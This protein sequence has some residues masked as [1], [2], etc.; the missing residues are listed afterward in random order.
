M[1]RPLKKLSPLPRALALL[2]AALLL[3][4]LVAGALHHHV[5]EDG[6]RHCVICSL[7]HVPVVT[8]AAAAGSAPTVPLERVVVVGRAAPV[9]ACPASPS[10][11]S[12]PSL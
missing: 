11:R 6:S 12:P 10:S 2:P 8:T 3:L 1:V 5:C 9:A 7:S 4:A